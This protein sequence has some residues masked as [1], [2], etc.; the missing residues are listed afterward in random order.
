[1]VTIPAGNFLMGT[2]VEDRAIDLV[3]GR[4]NANEEPRHEVTIAQ[5]FALGQ[6]EVTVQ[7]N[8]P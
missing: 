7:S 3:S 6:Y 2:V 1:M 8:S 4:P 5:P